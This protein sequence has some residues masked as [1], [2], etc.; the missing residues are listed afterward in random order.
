MYTKIDYPTTQ[1]FFK[2]TKTTQLNFSDNILFK[3]IKAETTSFLYGSMHFPIP[4]SQCLSLEAKTAFEKADCV[5]F[6]MIINLQDQQQ[7]NAFNLKLFQWLSD[8]RQETL[9]QSNAKVKKIGDHLN[10]VSDRP[11]IERYHAA[12]QT[13]SSKI[14]CNSNDGNKVLT[15]L[16]ETSLYNKAIEL[17]KPCFGLTGFANQL[18]NLWGM[19]LTYSEQIELVEHL[20]PQVNEEAARTF[21]ENSKNAY[22]ARDLKKVIELAM[23]LLGKNVLELKSVD[24]Y[25]HYLLYKSNE[26]F[27]SNLEKYLPKNNAFIVLGC[28]HLP[29]VLENLISRGYQVE[30][31]IESPLNYALETIQDD[32]L[33]NIAT[34]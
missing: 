9:D 26:I 21:I 3:I 29:G 18:A 16:F 15:E 17:N 7:I 28:N 20:L 32:N 22:L 34:L 27:V 2:N 23:G 5:I 10:F 19:E 31:V 24:K 14:L 30:P 33:R 12:L 11:P 25:L 6:E 8:N 4:G 1:S 13:L